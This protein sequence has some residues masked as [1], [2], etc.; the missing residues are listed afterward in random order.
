MVIRMTFNKLKPYNQLPA[1]PPSIDLETKAILK[2][3][4][5]ANKALAELKGA[6]E[7]IPNQ[8]MLINAIPLQEAKTSSEIENI[9]TTQDE[10]FKAELSG[11]KDANP[12][13]KEVL[14]Y[15]SALKLG[16]EALRKRPI[17]INHFRQIC[18]TLLGRDV[19]VRKIPGTVIKNT[20]SGE[21]L[22]TPPM[23]ERVILEKLA[24]LEKYIY[25]EDEVDPLIRLALIHYQFEAIHP[26]H[27]GNGRTGRIINILYLVEKGLLNVP[28]L[29][30]SR[31]IIQHKADYYSNLRKVTEEGK[32][33]PWILFMLEAVEQTARWTTDKIR[34]IRV[35]FERTKEV[36]KSKMTGG[37]YSILW[38]FCTT[39]LIAGLMFWSRTVSPKDKRPRNTFVHWR[40]GKS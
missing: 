4:I 5:R 26:F 7:L 21:V 30:L 10:L 27:D 35:S 19:T 6:G 13:T 17:G 11:G 15:R 20:T 38:R 40:A 2:A 12:N 3:C 31:H 1:L 28:V 33:E 32:W 8:A 37:A 22:Y 34:Q 14:R 25:T 39:S 23:G 29:Y 18:G 16:Y 9:V 36:C 24:A